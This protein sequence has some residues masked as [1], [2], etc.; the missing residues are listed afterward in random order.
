MHP[1]TLAAVIMLGPALLVSAF[2]FIVNAI[3]GN[4]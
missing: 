2:I 3:V 1:D 4:R